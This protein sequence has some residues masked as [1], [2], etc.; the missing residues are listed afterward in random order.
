MHARARAGHRVEVPR[1][2]QLVNRARNLVGGQRRTRRDGRRDA[3]RSR[4]ARFTGALG[5]D[6]GDYYRDDGPAGI[7]LYEPAPPF[8]VLAT[9]K[10]YQEMWPEPLRSRGLVGLALALRALGRG[11]QLVAVSGYAQPE[12]VKKAIEAGFDAHVAKPR[13]I[14]ELERLLSG[15][16]PWPAATPVDLEVD[17][18][19]H[20]NGCN[21]RHGRGAEGIR[22]V[23]LQPPRRGLGADDQHEKTD[24]PE[25]EPDAA[26]SRAAHEFAARSRRSGRGRRQIAQVQADGARPRRQPAS[27]FLL[28]HARKDTAGAPAASFARGTRPCQRRTPPSRFDAQ[29]TLR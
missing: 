27:R 1:H 20:R 10:A 14:A 9:N 19:P 22:K 23:V 4:S 29:A 18:A 3:A 8:R 6:A 25:R 11:M 7:V 2:A 17:E 13:D 15:Q 21:E 16:E 5:T 28:G 24:E 26:R 12:D